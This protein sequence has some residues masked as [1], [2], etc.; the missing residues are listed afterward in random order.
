MSERN[1]PIKVI[2]RFSL[3]SINN[4]GLIIVRST[5]GFVPDSPKPVSSYPLATAPAV[6]II[7][8]PL[9][10]F[11]YPS[12]SRDMTAILPDMVSLIGPSTLKDKSL[13]L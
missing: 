12:L 2:S 13:L 6:G 10:S 5:S 7:V 3:G 11:Q 4:I 8:P 9:L 1:S